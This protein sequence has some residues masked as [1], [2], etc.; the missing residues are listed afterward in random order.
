MNEVAAVPI[1]IRTEFGAHGQWLKQIWRLGDVAVYER[2]LTKESLPHEL[3]LI[4]IRV[5][6]ERLM[7]NGDL[8]EAREAYPGD[9][10]WGTYGWS[11]PIKS[12]VLE[13]A[14]HVQAFR[15]HRAT[16]MRESVAAFKVAGR[17]VPR[18]SSCAAQKVA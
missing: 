10:A 7:P 14:V 2:S 12:F 1:P 4:I 15:R 9:S 17:L 13:L 11:F 16:F 5:R 8:V 6:D 18:R 3:E